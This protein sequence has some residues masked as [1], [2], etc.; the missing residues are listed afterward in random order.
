VA[1]AV[2]AFLVPN[3]PFLVLSPHAWVTGVLTP[4]ASHTVP[5]GQGLV[6]LTLFLGLGGGSL[7]AYTV[8][9][10]VVYVSLWLAFV[11]TYPALK[12]WAVLCPTVVLFFGARSFGSYLVTLL[13]AALV[14]ATSVRPTGTR[15]RPPGPVRRWAPWIVV[16]GLV[17]SLA[18]LG[19]VFSSAAP[20]TV[21]IV[22]VRTT[23]QLAT[24]VEL[25]VD[26]DN[27][28]GRAVVP[29]FT[30]ESGGQLTAFWTAQGGPPSLAP[31]VHAH[32]TLL[33]PNFFAQPPITGGFQ[34]VAFTSAP[35]SVSAS[36]SYLP[37]TFHVALDPTS[38]TRTLPL[39]EPVTLHAS[40]LDL[41]DRPVRQAGV[42]VYLGQ[43]IYGQQGL[44]FG[45]AIINQG[46]IG[47]TPVVAFTDGNGVA[48]F[49]V[50]GTQSTTDPVYFEAN[51]V[52]P[53]QFY[54][55]GYSEIVPIRFGSG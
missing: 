35:A 43:V 20:L 52:D 40:V 53:R 27:R 42:P 8:A 18:S 33:A 37:T 51:L 29:S 15:G 34:V 45:Q 9:A 44:V 13:P 23:G 3:L 49:V 54:P 32:Y 28:S 39:G 41:V 24:V 47:Q 21:R 4:I 36:P 2:A 6:G 55:Y 25:G 5:A 10:V 12:A 14:A 11:A 31:G 19:A 48:T 46:Q 50:R 30:V 16:G 7:A 17:A 26:V 38:V 1:I 22:S